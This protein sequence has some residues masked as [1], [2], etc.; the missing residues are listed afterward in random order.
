MPNSLSSSE[1]SDL[2]SQN[3]H[4][5]AHELFSQLCTITNLVKVGPKR[6]LFL[7][8]VN[9]GEGITRIWRDWL[10]EQ[11]KGKVMNGE[12]GEDNLLWADTEQHVGLRMR[13]DEKMDAPA[14]IL[15][16]AG[17]EVAVS[18]TLQYEG[19]SKDSA[20]HLVTIY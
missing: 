7:S 17:E 3:I 10:T 15:T 16:S 6:G 14:P 20:L 5:E 13:V 4:L 19:M 11:T 2:V 18:Y 9:I 8:C 1:K 12:E